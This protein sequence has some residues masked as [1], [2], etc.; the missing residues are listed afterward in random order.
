MA[1]VSDLTNR[2][3]SNAKIIAEEKGHGFIAPASAADVNDDGYHDIIVI[4][5]GSTAFAID[6]KDQRMLWQRNFKN[7]ECSNSFAIGYFTD[8]DVPD[9][10]TFVSKGQWPNSTGSLQV[11]LDGK[12]G[13]VAYMDSI[14][15]TGYS[16]PVVYDL[17]NDGRDEVI[18]SI[19]EYDCSVGFVG[20][21]PGV[22]EN[23]LTAID[24]GKRSMQIIDQSQGFKN[25]FSTP[26]LGDLDDD[27]YLDIVHCQYFHYGDLM[28][29]LGMRL[30]R[31]DTPIRIRERPFWG[32]YMGTNGDG[33]FLK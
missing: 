16:S 17:N 18:I 29:F 12:T 24:F 27:G 13:D 25:I 7:T 10:F 23:R 2:K 32:A 8:D 30:K 1:K 9:F 19:N 22:M 11:M 14:G 31:I 5:H 26:W 20:K 15:C 21:A 6:G 33:V 3:L 4:S 28:L